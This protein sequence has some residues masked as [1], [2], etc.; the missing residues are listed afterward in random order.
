M[1]SPIRPETLSE[2]GRYRFDERLG[3]LCEG[4]KPTR[5]QEHL[6]WREAVDWDKRLDD[7]SVTAKAVGG[8]SG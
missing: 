2:E 7:G 8:S 1:S 4:G 5:M 3:I 6:A